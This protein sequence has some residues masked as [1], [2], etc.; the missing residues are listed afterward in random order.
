[1]PA[2]AADSDVGGVTIVRPWTTKMFS[3]VHSDTD[4]SAESSTASS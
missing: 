1:M 4:P 2:S 3:P